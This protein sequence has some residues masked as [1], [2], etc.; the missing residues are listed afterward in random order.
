M[1]LRVRRFGVENADRFPA[2]TS[3]GQFLAELDHIIADFAGGMAGQIAGAQRSAS[4]TKART[5][6]ALRTDLDVIARTARS[7]EPDIPELRG[8]FPRS[9]SL[10]DMDL[11]ALARA[12]AGYATPWRDQFVAHAL[13][14]NFLE[15]L[16]A[17]IANFE[18]A[19]ERKS[20][21]TGNRSAAVR[22]LDELA[23]RGAGIVTRLDA[24]VRN[25]FRG[26][27]GKLAEWKR[28]RTLDKITGRGAVTEA[29]TQ[30]AQAAQAAAA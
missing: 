20:A 19:V 27:E 26:N 25:T 11:I 22:T 2:S 23:G 7:L 17:D 5:R 14:E 13:P 29:K 24:I 9:N 30:K 28:A 16:L 18:A 3:G 15:D 10:S 4:D 6:Q 1:F 21:A 12:Y 8:K